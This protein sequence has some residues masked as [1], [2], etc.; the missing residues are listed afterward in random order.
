MNKRFLLWIIVL[1][2]AGCYS[3]ILP[4]HCEPNIYYLGAD[5]AGVGNSDIW[6][7]NWVAANEPLYCEPYSDGY[8]LVFEDQ[9]NENSIDESLWESAAW[10]SQRSNGMTYFIDR[11]QCSAIQRTEDVEE[12]DGLLHIKHSEI[13]PLTDCLLPPPSLT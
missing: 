1:T 6:E 2:Y 4:Y 3:Q 12:H 5:G 10:K 7:T 13:S 8:I 9:F 11:Q